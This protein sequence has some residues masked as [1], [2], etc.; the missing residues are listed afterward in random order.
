MGRAKQTV[1]VK[2]RRKKSDST[3]LECNMCKGLGKVPRGYNKRK[4]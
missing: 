1:K 3:W 2:T 4:K